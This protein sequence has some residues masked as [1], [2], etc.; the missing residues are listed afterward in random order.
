MYRCNN[1]ECEFEEPKKGFNPYP[2]FGGEETWHCPCC[3]V[4]DMFEEIKEEE[5]D[6]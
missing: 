1:C 2:D 4:A 3:G 6:E 5:D